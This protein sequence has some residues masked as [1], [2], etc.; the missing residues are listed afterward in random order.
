MQV[1]VYDAEGTAAVAGGEAKTL[2][3]KN[4]EFAYT[5]TNTEVNTNYQFRV[6]SAH[7]AQFQKLTLVY[8]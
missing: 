7:N 2:S 1:G 8:E 6:V 5:L 3:E 4:A